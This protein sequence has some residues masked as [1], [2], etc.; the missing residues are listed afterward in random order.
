[1][2]P[3]SSK[4]IKELR[5]EKMTLI[6]DVALNHFANH[7]FKA[8]T[9]NHIAQHAGISK[10]LMY[11]YFKSKEDLLASI[12]EKSVSELYDYFDVNR[13]GYLT[14]EEFEFFIRKA[15]RVL[16]EKQPF[17]RLFFQVLLQNEVRINFMNSFLGTES[18]ITFPQSFSKESF[19][20]Q[21]MRIIKDYFIR[22]K[23][24][25]GPDYDPYLEL[26]MFLIT[27][28]GFAITYI[29]TE[30][31]NDEYFDKTVNYIIDIF[32]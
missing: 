25:R 22:K 8:T 26:N 12:I 4:R 30:E 7:G 2:S 27:L 15:A 16:N 20:S 10:G 18:L 1:M 31:E 19:I 24:S 5:E 28:K 3:R 21:I 23:A 13:D 6:M 29:Y 9:I 14:Q 32:K 11:N 17:W